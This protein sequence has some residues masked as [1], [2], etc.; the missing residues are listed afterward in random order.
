M[1]KDIHFSLLAVKSFQI[2]LDSEAPFR[3]NLNNPEPMQQ[4]F[5][6]DFVGRVSQKFVE[7]AFSGWDGCLTKLFVHILLKLQKIF[8][9]VQILR[10]NFP[11]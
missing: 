10:E 9:K 5:V 1:F 6:Q 2:F 3:L 11:L 7:S 8:R 4:K